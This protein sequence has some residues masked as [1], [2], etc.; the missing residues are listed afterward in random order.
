MKHHKKTQT[1]E[2]NPHVFSQ[3]CITEE[4]ILPKSCSS[5]NNITRICINLPLYTD[6]FYTQANSANN[7]TQMALLDVFKI[8]RFP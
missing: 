7:N 5:H 8:S 4:S 2:L 3:P 6:A 1:H